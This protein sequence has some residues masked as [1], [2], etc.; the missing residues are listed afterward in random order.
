LF[1]APGRFLMGAIPS[2]KCLSDTTEGHFRR[3]I[4]HLVK[5]IRSHLSPEGLRY[6]IADAKAQTILLNRMDCG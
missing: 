4:Y 1:C 2:R 3:A 6:S 5:R